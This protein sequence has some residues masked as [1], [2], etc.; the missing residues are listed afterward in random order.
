M[1]FPQTTPPRKLT[2]EERLELEARRVARD[3]RLH[4]PSLTKEERQEQSALFSMSRAEYDSPEVQSLLPLGRDGRAPVS[5]WLDPF[6]ALRPFQRRTYI[7]RLETRRSWTR[8]GRVPRRARRVRVRRAVS[9]AGP[10]DGPS[11]GPEE[12]PSAPPIARDAL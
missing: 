3:V 1:S 4:G 5:P 2:P 10:S 12:P 6:A 9:R 8:A 11:P 7:R